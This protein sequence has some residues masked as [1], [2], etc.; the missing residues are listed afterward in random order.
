MMRSTT[1]ARL[2]K[3]VLLGIFIGMSA[4]ACGTGYD[5]P[6]LLR[7]LRVLAVQK[8]A[9]YAAPGQEVGLQMLW[10]DAREQAAQNV[11]RVWISG[12]HNPPGDSYQ[13]CLEIL[14]SL[15]DAG[16]GALLDQAFERARDS[17]EGRVEIEISPDMLPP[18]V[19]VVVP[20]ALTIVIEITNEEEGG[21]ED[22]LPADAPFRMTVPSNLIESRPPSKDPDVPRFGTS[23]VYFALCS[24][25]LAAGPPNAEGLPLICADEDG[26]AL[27]SDDFVFGYSQVLAYRPEDGHE[28]NNPVVE[29][30]RFD[31]QVVATDA[32][33]T[34]LCF[35]SQSGA[36]STDGLAPCAPVVNRGE[37]SPDAETP[38]RRPCSE[39]D[40]LPMVSACKAEGCRNYLVEPILS[41]SVAE[42]DTVQAA[43]RGEDIYEQ[44]WVNYYVDSGSLGSDVRVLNDATAGWNPDYGTTFTP[45]SEPGVSY[46]WAAP[47]DNRGGVGWV[48][49]AVCVQ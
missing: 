29:G 20:N 43:S 27:L 33:H 40:G 21:G 9:P 47:H 7:Q 3:G 23:F 1:W 13:V 48:R 28:N 15:I 46:V 19:G 22:T 45:P 31:G 38:T 16:A 44:M 10:Q 6:S 8:D 12:C 17:E 39:A 25:R 14:G 2:A 18:E 24:G 5:A 35:D 34:A 37:A 49:F 32:P 41:E 4:L 42:L 11:E 26:Q 36:Q 30:L